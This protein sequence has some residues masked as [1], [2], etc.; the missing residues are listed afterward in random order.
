ML[1]KKIKRPINHSNIIG[2][3]EANSEEVIYSNSHL[4]RN[5][6]KVDFKDAN[7]SE[8]LSK[9]VKVKPLVSY[10]ININLSTSNT[11]ISI[12]DK[13]GNLKGYYTSGTL[14]FKGSQKT[15]KYTLITILKNFL[16]NFNYINNKSVII[17]FKGVIK[18][19]KLF[20]KKLKEK[21][22]IKAITYKN[23]LP[24]NGCRPKKIRRK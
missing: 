1:L 8:F 4:N 22:S 14:G 16:Y 11:I 2:V 24:H 18:D 7:K 17:N 10:I 3:M 20:I 12:T 19:Q 15:K 21:V 5:L 13:Q 6:I 9:N 23:S